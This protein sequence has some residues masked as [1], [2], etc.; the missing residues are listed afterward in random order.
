MS[1]INYNKYILLNINVGLPNCI[2]FTSISV[3]IMWKP[4]LKIMKNMKEQDFYGC[5]PIGTN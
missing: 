3:H 2:V 4:Y 5:F 1:C